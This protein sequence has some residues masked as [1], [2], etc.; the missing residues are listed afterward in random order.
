V[1][2]VIVKSPR[3]VAAP[4]VAPKAEA[5]PLRFLR[6]SGA[7]CLVLIGLIVVVFWPV[8]TFDY[9]NYDDGDYASA[10]PHVQSGLSR[11]NLIWAFTSGHASNWHPLTWLSHQLDC[12]WFG[13]RP[14]PQHLVN[15]AFH[16]F[17]AVLLLLVLQRM[18]GAL[19][20]SALVAALFALHPLRVE[21]VAWISERKDVL[22]GLFFLLTLGAYCKYVRSRSEMA[23]GERKP[24]FW[25]GLALLCFGLGLMSKP[26]LVT[27][28]FLLLLLD[29]W[30][31]GRW[32]L[33][34]AGLSALVRL[35]IEK[36]P[37]L[38]LAVV[39]S[40]I[41]FVVQRR[42]GA[43]ST[44]LSVQAR[45]ANA[46]VSYVRYIGKTICPV[47][48][49]V[50]Y[51]HPG[52]WALWQ[53]LGAATLL[54]V[55]SLMVL[56]QARRRPY[57]LVG[58]LWFLGALIPVIGL[59]Q[60]GIQ[61]MA[62]RYTY[63]PGIGLLILGIWGVAEAVQSRVGAEKP[64]AVAASLL[65]L[66]CAC[67][68]RNQVRFWHDSQTLFQRAVDVTSD[69]YLAYNN[70]G[71]YLSGKGDV[72]RAK[73]YYQKSLAISPLYSDALNNLGF[74]L[75]GE[76]KYAQAL[77][78]Y[79]AALRTSPNQPEIHN[80]LGN[81]LSELGHLN[82]AVQEYLTAL[83][84]Q[85][86]HAEAHNNLGIALAMQGKLDEAQTHF[87]AAI[88]AKPGYAS[89]HSNLGNALAVQ[90]KLAEATTEYEQ[91]LRLNP[92]DPQAHNNL[93]N[94]LLE[95][96]QLQQAI[97]QYGQ[98]LRLKADNPEAHFNLAVAFLRTNRRTEAAEHLRQVL[99]LNPGN[100][101]ARRQLELL[102]T[103]K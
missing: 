80:N 78:L 82:E 79:E 6:R 55:I 11:A 83:R 94:V 81:A 24:W 91:S 34:R 54:L 87:R 95:Q 65:V 76:G 97:A 101:E 58:W 9:V 25:Y 41:T 43:V 13:P 22:S 5:F 36:A 103:S 62:D 92:N 49:S 30:P 28:P 84:L 20:R 51:P 74:A 89:A 64:A 98:A 69:N 59:V 23:S 102:S 85:P 66:G 72:A 8:G 44:V 93:G 96:D 100:L 39:S 7:L 33:D 10:N 77:P 32:S 45:V 86:D 57:L 14:G 42:G 40:V 56:I 70:L 38:M 3:E 15:V 50:L 61:S 63:V 35:T 73:E 31:F 71:Y 27:T 99:R 19:W 53:V 29:Y 26:M 16:A 90:H 48:L 68:S 46:L 18:T 17:N 2:K 12:Q 88:E 37:F 67:A 47:N 4:R 21:S 52:H 1:P 75:A 60:V